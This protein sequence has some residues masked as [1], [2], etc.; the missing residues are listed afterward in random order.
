MATALEYCYLIKPKFVRGLGDLFLK[1]QL[2][3]PCFGTF[4]TCSSLLGTQMKMRTMLLLKF[5]EICLLIFCCF[6]QRQFS[7][8]DLI[9]LTVKVSIL[10]NGK[11]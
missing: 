8:C 1:K 6:L 2:H 10:F 3:K 5:A 11:D 4:W 7:Y 9:G